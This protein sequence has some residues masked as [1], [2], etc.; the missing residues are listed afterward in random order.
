V[1]QINSSCLTP[2]FV[3]A[4]R[5]DRFAKAAASG[6]D[7]VVIDLEDAVPPNDKIGAR[8]ALTREVLPGA[9]TILRV[10][11]TASPWFDD[12]LAAAAKLGLGCVMVPKFEDPAVLPKLRAVLGPVEIIALIESAKGLA[13][14]RAIAACGVTRLGFGFIDLAADL[15]CAHRRDILAPARLEIVLA[16]RL[17]G[18]TPPLEGVTTSIEDGDEAE[19]DARYACEFGFSGKMCIHPKQ[20]A[21]VKAG[22]RPSAAEVAWATAIMVAPDDGAARIA[23]SM[24]DAPVRQQARQI[25]A[26]AER[27]G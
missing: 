25:L 24:V 18:L 15:G 17:A 22:F 9:P 23:G 20:V 2:L 7:A 26:R 11:A 21:R 19:A 8:Q 3:P 27:A 10:N 6:A 1:T 13:N 4:T 5:I 12:D 16:S 14:A